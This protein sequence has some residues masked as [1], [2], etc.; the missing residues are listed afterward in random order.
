MG[1]MG[2]AVAFFVVFAATGIATGV[3]LKVLRRRAILDLPN[4][5]SSHTIPTPRGGGIAVMAV[6]LPAWAA[7]ALADGAPP[8]DLLAVL[9]GALVLAAVSWIDDLRTLGWPIRLAVQLAAVALGLAAMAEDGLFFQGYLPFWLDRLAAAFLWLWFINLFNFMDGIDGMAGTEAACLGGGLALIA[10]ATGWPGLTAPLGLAV[11]AA[12]LGFL[13]WNWPPAK[14]FLG[15]VGSV[16][17]GYLL[18]W[19]LLDAAVAGA[20]AAALILPAYYLADATITLLRRLS[21]GEPIFEPHAQHFYQQAVRGGSSHAEVVRAVLFANL[22][23]I[24]LALG[25][26]RG[27]V[28]AALVGAAATVAILLRYLMRELLLRYLLRDMLS[29]RAA[30]EARMNLKFRLSAHPEIAFFHD[31]AMAAVSFVLSLYL[32]LGGETLAYAET[33][34]PIGTMLF[35]GVAAVVFRTMGL[36]RGVWRYA[37][38]DD[39]LAIARAVTLIILI[40]LP[41]MFLVTRLE[42]L[43]R[44]VLVINWFVLMILLG[45]P[46]LVYRVIKDGSLRHVLERGNPFRVPVLLVGAGNAADA[47]IRELARDK[48]APFEVVGILDD[49]PERIGRRIRGVT[50]N[51]SID[52]AQA[53][54]DGLRRSGRMPQRFVVTRGGSVGPHKLRHLLAVAEANGMTLARLPRITE[55][56]QGDGEGETPLTMKP[57][58]VEDLLGRPRTVLDR[59]PMQQLVAGRRVLVTGAGGSI[60]S[61]LVRQIAE[62]GPSH[63]ALLDHAEF[64]LYE[65]D[66]EVRERWPALS[67]RAVLADIRDR[68]RIDRVMAAERP[69]LVFHAAALKH[70]PMAELNPAEATLTN[71][72]GTRNL[73]EACRAAGAKAMVLISTDKAVNPTSV[74]GATKRLAESYCQA[75]DIAARSPDG[76]RGEGAPGDGTRYITVRFGNVLGSAGSVVPLFQRQLAEGGPLTVTHPDMTRYFMTIREAVEL[77]LQASALGSGLGG[78]APESG[79][80][81]VLDMGEPVKVLDLARQMIRLA[82]KRPEIDIEIRFTG[83]RPGEKLTEELF[84]SGETLES[85]PLPGILLA[86]PRTADWKLLRSAFDELAEAAAAGRTEQVLALLQRLVPEYEAS[87]VQPLSAVAAS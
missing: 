53:V 36:Y 17:L 68:A 80:I 39:L 77:V 83:V 69:D 16:P 18:G 49:K 43:P 55:L 82:G 62:F 28:L 51:G 10:L 6:L 54:I 14:L 19:L 27:A 67:S 32:R 41:L 23:L 3:V 58:A 72:I 12:A 8:P 9:A 81:F 26:T 29:L 86:G 87:E 7:I 1:W 22:V 38:M 79:K 20:W 60:G 57:I 2:L 15:D 34:L 65:I 40:F 25:A 52:S 56:K 47:F 61:E 64:L 37:S 50:V 24:A 42:A 74:L 30:K 48:A 11:V 85:T 13:V 84:H 73:A 63:L 76:R 70:V 59:S 31:V 33:F 44:S 5:R 71:V 45:A 46:R 78:G 66:R 4:H 21:R 35:T 75:L